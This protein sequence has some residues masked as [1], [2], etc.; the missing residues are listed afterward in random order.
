MF[1]RTTNMSSQSPSFATETRWPRSSLDSRFLR[2]QWSVYGCVNK[3]SKRTWS[4]PSLSAFECDHS[5]GMSFAS[6]RASVTMNNKFADENIMQKTFSR[7]A[8]VR[9]FLSLIFYVMPCLGSTSKW[10]QTKIVAYGMIKR[11]NAIVRLKAGGHQHKH[12]ATA[13]KYTRYC[14]AFTLTHNVSTAHNTCN[15]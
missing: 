14:N 10:I 2:P 12:A 7:I 6:T 11:R 5:T 4:T 8:S 9:V 3:R 1:T 15:A 13:C